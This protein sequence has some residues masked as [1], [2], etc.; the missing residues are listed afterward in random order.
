MVLKLSELQVV[1]FARF[2]KKSEKIIV[3]LWILRAVNLF[4]AA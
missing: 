2:G 3:T 1:A 4:V